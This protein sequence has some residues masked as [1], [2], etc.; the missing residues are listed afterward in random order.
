MLKALITTIPFGIKNRLPLEL[1]ESENIKYTINPYNKKINENQLTELI[2]DY[3]FLIAGTEIISKKVLKAASKLKLISRVGIGLDGIDLNIARAQGIK[4]SYTPDAPAK[5]VSDLTIGLMINLLRNVHVSNTKMHNG[6]WERLYGKRLGEVKI[7]IIGIGRIGA[8]VLGRLQGFG[9]NKI[10]VNDIDPKKHLETIFNI[11]WCE[12]EKIFKDADIISLHVPLTS[13]TKNMIGIK[14]LEMMKSDATLINTARGG[15]INEDD[16]YR[17]MTKGHLSGSA[18]DVFE[19]EP[20]AGPL[21]NIDRCLLTS[22]MGSM[23]VDCR[24]R[25]EIEATEEVVR[26]KKK[27]V[28]KNLIPNYFYEI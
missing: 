27:E 15:I 19:N 16:L 21:K 9:C 6:E 17:V 1:L 13:K 23:S 26:F 8:G 14:E 5:A 24:S 11:E 28:L 12:K 2:P 22:H 7:G 20:Y 18:I 25:M 3:D 4:I 10:L